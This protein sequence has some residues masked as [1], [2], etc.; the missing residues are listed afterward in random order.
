MNEVIS[1]PRKQKDNWPISE[2]LLT[3]EEAPKLEYGNTYNA[4]IV[5]I[6]DNGVMVTLYP[7]M[8]PTLLPN[9][10]TKPQKDT[11][12][13]SFESSSWSRYFSEIF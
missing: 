7:S 4:K 2:K 1:Q 9:K 5:E 6:R 13:L 10:T 11:A 12:S 8:K 3:E